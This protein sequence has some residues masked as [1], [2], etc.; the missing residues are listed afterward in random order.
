MIRGEASQPVVRL[1]DTL[2]L[3][4]HQRPERRDSAR[5]LGCSPLSCEVATL[6][7]FFPAA[8]LASTSARAP[9]LTEDAL[10]G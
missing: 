7:Y 4:V 9:S 3:Q 6:S 2:R 5:D 10:A 8:S 1:R